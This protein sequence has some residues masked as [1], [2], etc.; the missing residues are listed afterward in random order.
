[1]TGTLFTDGALGPYF[2]EA[3]G[4][5][6]S[7]LSWCFHIDDGLR[8]LNLSA[9]CPVILSFLRPKQSLYLP[10]S[11]PVIPLVLYA[12]AYWFICFAV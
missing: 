12:A 1:M 4:G 5:S 3:K 6:V 9:C 10:V 8:E 2:K 7:C 11:R